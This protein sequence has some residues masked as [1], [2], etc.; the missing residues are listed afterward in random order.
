MAREALE[1]REVISSLAEIV[2]IFLGLAIALALSRLRLRWDWALAGLPLTAALWLAES[3]FVLASLSAT[4]T[5]LAFAL[6]FR[7]AGRLEGGEAERRAREAIGPL[8]LALVLLRW[9]HPPDPFRLPR[10]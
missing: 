8:Q 4:A 7:L 10:G 5:A 2:G 3:P 6:T 1:V 9:R